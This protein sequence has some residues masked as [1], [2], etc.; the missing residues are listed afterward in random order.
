[1]E[2]VEGLLKILEVSM[3]SY[4]YLTL[5]SPVNRNYGEIFRSIREQRGYRIDDF[6]NVGISSTYLSLFESGQ[7]MIPFDKIEEMMEN[8]NLVAYDYVW[9]FSAGEKDNFVALFDQIECAFYKNDRNFLKQVYENRLTE[10]AIDQQMIAYAAKACY[11]ELSAEEAEILVGF[12]M[13]VERWTS[14]ELSVLSCTAPYLDNTFIYSLLR[15]FERHQDFLSGSMYY[16]KRQ[17]QAVVRIMINKAEKGEFNI[18]KAAYIYGQGILST[19]D[20]YCRLILQFAH[21]YFLSCQG[22]LE[23]GKQKMNEI[24]HLVNFLNDKALLVKLQKVYRHF[25][26]R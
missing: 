7:L 14:F 9:A 6:V 21:G 1:M 13:G 22:Q 4:L 8:M 26:K 10:K 23:A 18:A 15:N 20:E 25:E 12:L 11:T 16:L 17:M 2:K 24:I 19:G 5:E 3:L